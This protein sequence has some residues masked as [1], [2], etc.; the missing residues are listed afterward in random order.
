[1]A[2]NDLRARGAWGARS[3]PPTRCWGV[4]GRS[5]VAAALFN[6][7]PPFGLNLSDL[8][9][10]DIFHKLKHKGL[11][12]IL[13][14]EKSASKLILAGFTNICEIESME[15]KGKRMLLYSCEKPNFELGSSAQLK[16]VDSKTSQLCFT[17][18]Q[19]GEIDNCNGNLAEILDE[20]PYGDYMDPDELLE[21]IDLVKPTAE[22][23]KVCGTTGKR[24]ACKDCSCG[25]AEELEVEKGGVKSTVKTEIKSSCGSCYLGDAFR[26]ASC[27]Y[28]GMP[29]FKPGE[30][31]VLSDRQL[32]PDL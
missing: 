10:E 12:F 13:G 32:A 28:L 3:A 7:L 15:Y 19:L 21:E 5:S 22:S 30:K 26:C 25:L 24:K 8:L 23:L 1:M 29:A 27:P 31:I 2:R 14:Q 18:E 6:M 20:E 4:I 16:G 17:E 11:L 9:L